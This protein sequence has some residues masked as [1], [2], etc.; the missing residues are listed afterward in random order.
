MD[1]LGFLILAVMTF[2]SQ[3][4]Y[5]TSRQAS[6]ADAVCL[7]ADSGGSWRNA[8]FTSQTS[9]FTAT[10]DATPT[11]SPLNGVV[12]LSRGAQAA[13]A[14]FGVLV[15]FNPSGQIDARNGGAY[16]AASSIPYAAGVS[17]HFRVEVNVG[18]H[19]YSA[20]VTP[21]GGV[22][23]TIG[24]NFA[25]RTEQN[26]VASLDSW[27]A[28]VASSPAGS[29][30]VCDFALG[31][32]TD[33]PPD[34]TFTVS[35][36]SALQSRINSAL[37]G[38]RIILTNGVYTA[39]AAITVARQ[40][41]AAKPI[42]IESQ[43]V[44]GAEIR[45]S[46][47]FS[48]DSPSA[49]VV[50]RG[51][52]FRHAA[53]R[54][55][56]RSGTHHCRITRN[57]FQLTG[58][59][60]YLTVSGDDSE[61]DHNTFQNKTT[62]GNMLSIQG[63]GG[64]GMAQ[65]VF[66]HHNLFQDFSNIGANG[67]E[68]VRV[69]LSGRS[70]TAAHTLMERNLFVRCNGE[71][72]IIS[73]KSGANVYRFNT[74]RDSTGELTLRH[75]NGCTVHSNFFINSHGLRFF[76]DDHKIFSN[77]FERCDPAIQIGNGDTVIPPGQLTGHDQPERA[78]VSFNTLVNNTRN[79]LMPGRTSGLGAVDLVFSNNLIQSDAGVMLD[80]GG[81]VPGARFE[82]NI[83]FGAAPNGDLPGSGA[84]RVNPQLV[85]DSVGVFRLQSTSPAIDSAS[86]SFSEVVIDM[87]GQ[88]RSGSKD[89]GADEQQAGPI[90]N[91]PLTPA[92]VGPNA[93]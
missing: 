62:A 9:T 59:G 38:D 57:V 20:F 12:G 84:R 77:Y 45:G 41:T 58:T 17:H 42:S 44:G 82:N 27:G 37:P 89:V 86:G 51:F 54:A 21:A 40:G 53:G 80:L 8:T 61:V 10:F 78:R 76:G 43:T 68:T 55:N 72:E 87:D 32:Q 81:P 23:R 48:V 92:D 22:E 2:W 19:R 15:R 73:N 67:G 50:I 30:S 93:P 39:S 91:R 66:I 16:A 63:P 83:V 33:P 74:I 26:S 5:A 31:G 49:F 79:A 1:R 90:S 85:R 70:L 71:N 18:T 47:G 4:S 6:D 64:S 14:G 24:Q 60:N 69:G 13:Y 7:T 52:R 88:S 36:L 56:V 75:G 28:F 11:A 3:M 35:S 25:F 46:D 65:R 29:M 34:R